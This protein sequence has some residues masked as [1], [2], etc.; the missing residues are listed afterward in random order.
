M[1]TCELASLVFSMDR[2]GSGLYAVINN[3]MY[4][5]VKATVEIEY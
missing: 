4:T 2:I 3:S 1:R 5:V